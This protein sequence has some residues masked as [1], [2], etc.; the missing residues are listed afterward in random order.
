L[1]FNGCAEKR[2]FPTTLLR[3]SGEKLFDSKIRSTIRPA[4]LLFCGF[5]DA[6]FLDSSSGFTRRL[7]RLLTLSDHWEPSEPILD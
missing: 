7:Y 5:A 6:A 1:L 4:N 3:Q 2:P